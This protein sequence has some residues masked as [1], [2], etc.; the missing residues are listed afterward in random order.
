MN[1]PSKIYDRLV[2][3]HPVVLLILLTL[4]LS[5]FAFHARDFKLDASADSLILE[6]DEDLIKYNEII[7]RYDPKDFYIITYASHKDLFTHE[8]LDRFKSLR[9]QLT[10]LEGVDSIQSILDITLYETSGISLTDIDGSNVK[11]LRSP[12]VDLKAA[13]KEIIENP[14]YKEL[15]LNAKAPEATAIIINMRS[16]TPYW[17]LYNQR[18]RLLDKKAAG[19]LSAEE[20]I[21][22]EQILGEYEVLYT[23][24]I[25]QRHQTIEKIRSSI[26]P[27]KSYADIHLGGVPMIADD[28]MSFIKD[29]LI[30]F[31]VGVFIFIVA[32]L[33]LVFRSMQ[34]VIL[35]LLSCFY[36][37][38]LMM[39]VLGLW[40]WKV[41]V[42]SSNFISLM[43]ILTLSMNIH[44]AVR[45][46]Q[47]SRDMS[48]ADQVEIV[49]TTVRKM[50]WPCLYTALTTILAFS[51]LV[52]SGIKPVMDF[53]WMMTIGLTITFLTS[54][55]LLP[56]I[57]VL[58]KKAT[59][60][61]KRGNRSTITARLASIAEHHG[62][63]VIPVSALL[64]L[65]SIFGITKLQVENSFVNYFREH[66][67]IHTGMKLID[68]QDVGTVPLNIILEFPSQEANNRAE[69]GV[70]DDEFE[71]DD[72]FDWVDDY[73]PEDYW[74]T[75]YKIEKIK[76]VH[77]YVD[78]LPEV[79]TVMSLA[80]IVRFAEH[81]RKAA[82]DGLE[83][84]LLYKKVPA[85]LKADYIDPYVS[86]EH[87]EARISLL[88]RDSLPDLRR[89]VFLDDLRRNL[90]DRFDL[91][92]EEVTVSGVLVLYNN[93]LQ[94][95]FRSQILTLGIVLLGIWIMLLILFRS[96]RLSIIGMIPNILAVGVVLGLMGL[97]GIPLDMMTITIAA[98]T[99]GIAID[100]SIHYLYRYRE[101]FS[102]NND[103]VETLR[104]CHRNVGRAIL[105]TSVTVIFG[106]SILVFSNFIPTIYFG[107]FTGIAMFIAL[108]AIL[109][110]MP[111]LILMWRP[112]TSRDTG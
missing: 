62:G 94:S 40:D 71:E 102:H 10:L 15:I 5:F 93:M 92:E 86:V 23:D 16:D 76:A 85:Y 56:S 103:Y 70:P 45:C 55:L 88:I 39:G 105:N 60:E 58:L 2:L 18:S 96:I 13:R 107:I 41:T 21:R 1:G 99:M 12:D 34:W 6:D 36:A 37:V 11:T 112:F 14:I 104:I 109:T 7:Y 25:D 42:I 17:K 95:L 43:L 46:E 44:L 67:E 101:E 19:T 98:I 29:D 111:K 33:A 51:S 49:S 68:D 65:L 79:G 28:M 32:T 61:R 50:V 64:V 54:F 73:D 83:L 24:F 80:S 38:V 91:S 30:I 22:L 77:D 9:D 47:L 69:G 26:A 31:G 81:Y 90:M 82:L 108:M 78:G 89:K 3:G 57:L 20:H 59:P 110:L 48:S 72:A 66:T 52:F 8:S 100:N 106:F 97:L 75:P 84:G 74:I 35:P 87:N 27:F 63:K 4:L 53:G